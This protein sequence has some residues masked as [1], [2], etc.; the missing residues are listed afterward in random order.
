MGI[1]RTFQNLR[2]YHN[3]TV[4][5][6]VMCGR[7]RI[8][9]QNLPAILLHTPG[10]K[11]DEKELLAAAYYFLEFVGLE[12]YVDALPDEVSF[13]HQR[14]VEIARALALD[15]KLLLMDEP[16]SGLNDAET[17]S[18]AELLFK[19]R[20][21]GT[22]IFLVEHDIRLIMGVSDYV[23]V[24]QSGKNLAHGTTEEVRKDP[25]VIAAYIGGEV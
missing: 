10:I 13:G 6:N 17:E 25:K 21:Q 22:T 5:E 12:K 11:R 1:A 23:Q 14:L 3:L 18:L 24:M 15:P 19:I 7:H 9:K 2:L 4:L 20:Q 8:S 16:A